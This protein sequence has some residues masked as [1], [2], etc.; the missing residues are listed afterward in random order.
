MRFDLIVTWSATF[1]KEEFKVKKE[2]NDYGYL[3]KA[4]R[5]PNGKRKYIRAKT[6]KELDK[7]VLEF[8]IEMAQGKIVVAG[9][10]AFRDLAMQW[11]EQVKK[12]VVKPQTYK[13][14]EDR[15]TC[16]LV[17][18]L[19][20]M[21]ID[22]IKAIHIINMLNN[23]G[24]P[25]K[26]TNKYLL[27]TAR[28]IFQFAVENDLIPKSPV[29]GSVRASGAAK[30]DDRPLTPNQTKMLL[31]FCR[32]HEDPNVYLFTML[33]L[34]TGMRRGELVA[35]RWDCVDLNKGVVSVRRNYIDATGE[36]SDEL[37]TA[38][39]KRDI[40]IPLNVVAELRQV[41]ARSNST[42]VLAGPV[43]GH[44]A[45]VSYA[46][47]DKAWADA[48]VAEFKIHAH[49]LRKTFATRMIESGTDPKR[50]QYLLGHT[51]LDMTLGVYAKY[52]AESQ[53][54]KTRE[55]MTEA[56]SFVAN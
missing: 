20:D 35:L 46:R 33:A 42:Y 1:Y 48:G 50:V 14:Y 19:G 4:I 3:T 45:P 32:K 6:K 13:V 22:E 40:P 15:V 25:S 28:S 29:T 23:Y 53:A 17:P 39:A 37:K 24:Y 16:H 55:I 38:A 7:K 47:F 51:S 11:L 27:S 34:V 2:Y 8:Q 18:A 44:M 49:L 5:L 9:N 56:F 12:P 52:D 21:P 10:M 36:V 43:D 26:S 31:E 30:R 54:D 41:K